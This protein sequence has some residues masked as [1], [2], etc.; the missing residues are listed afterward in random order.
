MINVIIENKD[1][2]YRQGMI[3]VISQLLDSISEEETIF[4]DVVDEN[5]TSI[6][7]I[8]V[9]HFH[10]GESALCHPV[11]QVRKA[12]SIII[13]TYDGSNP[14]HLGVLPLCFSNIIFINRKDSLEKVKE[15]IFR[16][17]EER[18]LNNSSPLKRSCGSCQHCTLSPQQASVAAQI[19]SG[20]KTE[21]I[22]EDLNISYKTV[23]SHKYM[24]MRKFNLYTEH[25]LFSFL[26]LLKSQA[27]SPNFFNVNL[28]RIF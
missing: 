22:A 28:R 5:I 16:G 7:D 12:D 1:S 11:L 20:K 21:H 14:P 18:Y 17:W 10:P 24:I 23:N 9:K 26:N 2:L 19:Y 8:I 25:E 6:A 13:G 3:M 4:T 15:L 27:T